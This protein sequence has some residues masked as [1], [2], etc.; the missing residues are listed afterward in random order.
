ML[1]G[2]LSIHL[3]VTVNPL[4]F[5]QHFPTSNWHII[6]C[7]NTFITI[8]SFFPWVSFQELTSNPLILSKR[9]ISLYILFMYWTIKQG[10]NNSAITSHAL[11]DKYKIKRL[12]VWKFVNF[13][14]Q[15]LWQECSAVQEGWYSYFHLADNP[16]KIKPLM[17]N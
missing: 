3:I 13:L 5:L 14:L 17:N 11:H 4:I 1:W 6:K 7:A 9:H 2:F 15:F 8:S 10:R 12:H 16:I